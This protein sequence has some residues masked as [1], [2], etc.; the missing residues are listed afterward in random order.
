MRATASFSVIAIV[1]AALVVAATIRDARDTSAAA[2]VTRALPV[3]SPGTARNEL[4]A[5]II[6]MKARL[7]RQP[8]D[9]LAVLHLSQALLRVQRV[10]NDGRA[11]IDAE[12]HLRDFLKRTPAHY[13]SRRM[14]AAVLLSQHR[15]GDAIAE[16]EKLRAVDPVDGWNY[17]VIADGYIELGN[18]ERAFEALDRMG[19]LAPGPP[20]YARVAYA[21][22]L[23][24]DLDDALE[25]MRRAAD[26]TSPNDPESLAWHFCQIGDLLLQLGRIN[27]ARTMF[28]RGHETF[29]DHPLVIAG[30]AKVKVIEGDLAGARL[31]LQ[32]ELASAPTSDLAMTIGDL[33]TSLG[34]TQVA[35][36]YFKMAEQLERSV[37][38]F[39]QRQP[40]VLARFFAEHNINADQAV[41]LAEEAARTRHDIF[42]HDA[43]AYAYLKAGRIDAAKRASVQSLR[44]GARDPRVLWHA[45]EISFAARDRAV[46]AALLARI[47][48]IAG[49]SDVVVRAG[50]ETLRRNL[51]H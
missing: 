48:S 38:A 43:L 35:Q 6:E 11:V 47:P 42:T 21:L 39:G 16:A 37:W 12:T 46:A 22:E 30:R 5:T 13:E 18:Y 41:A 10:N 36:S 40:H 25:Y 29:P 4:S 31:L 45:A 7:A 27:E 3:T 2:A 50:I 23:K 19:Q 44:T 26:G 32:R 1:A 24:G 49:I 14:L 9:A 34:D 20:A 17:G 51:G 28:D 15:F 8:D 33:S